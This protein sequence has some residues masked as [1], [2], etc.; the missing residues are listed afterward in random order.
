MWPAALPDN[1][2]SGVPMAI[3]DRWRGLSADFKTLKLELPEKIYFKTLSNGQWILSG[4]GADRASARIAKQRFEA[5]ARL[6]A[7]A[8]GLQGDPVLAWCLELSKTE[9]YQ[10]PT[11]SDD[12]L[13]SLEDEDISDVVSA[14]IVVCQ[15]FEAAAIAG[16]PQPEAKRYPLRAQWLKDHMKSHGITVWAI[17]NKLGG[18]DKKTLN[19]I[20]AGDPVREDSLKSLAGALAVARSQV[21]DE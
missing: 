4:G 18:P 20:R 12:A 11:R 8:A 9:Y 3:A 19:R 16:S 14:S 17:S 15:Q 5:L 7:A 10:E 6:S 13:M 2:S 21:P 1:W